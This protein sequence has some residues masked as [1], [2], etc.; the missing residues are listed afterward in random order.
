MAIVNTLNKV[1]AVRQYSHG[2]QAGAC[3]QAVCGT[4]GM[5]LG[6]C[7]CIQVKPALGRG[8][9]EGL[10]CVVGVVVPCIER[11]SAVFLS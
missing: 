4:K 5:Q 2:K 8:L 11:K 7:W 6:E 10:A 9:W 3:W 1:V